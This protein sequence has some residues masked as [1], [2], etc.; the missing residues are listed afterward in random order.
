MGYTECRIAWVV[1]ECLRV[2][3]DERWYGSVSRSVTLAEEE[4]Q[5]CIEV[6]NAD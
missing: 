1:N 2:A 4:Y 3:G 6:L 5:E